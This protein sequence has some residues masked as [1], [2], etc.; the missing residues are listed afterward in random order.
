MEDEQCV[1][2]LFTASKHALDC[3]QSPERQLWPVVEWLI[4]VL[5]YGI[6]QCSGL[7]EVSQLDLPNGCKL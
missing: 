2:S 6:R 3:P 4:V 5:E 7:P 1:V